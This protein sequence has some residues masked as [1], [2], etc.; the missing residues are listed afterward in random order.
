MGIN[1]LMDQALTA[2]EWRRQLIAI[3][4]QYLSSTIVEVIMERNFDS[5][6][7]SAD[8]PIEKVDTQ[9]ILAGISR[10]AALFL[11]PAEAKECMRQLK[12]DAPQSEE[13]G[14][15]SESCVL[16]I[17]SNSDVISAR[18]DAAQYAMDH[19]PNNLLSIRTSTV[20]SELAR[21]MVLYA[22]GGT[23]TVEIVGDGVEITARDDGP[24]IPHLDAV[25]AGRHRS[26]KG[27]GMGLRGVKKMSKRFD[28]VTAEGQ[29]TLI[30]LRL[31][32]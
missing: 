20:V 9:K 11:K 18:R 27:M 12:S 1:S 2:G 13:A 30:K 24:G 28:I 31:E 29:G 7:I 17:R 25:M 21:N 14:P 3:M 6:G 23:V 26:R 19:L 5:V 4:S 16:E 8:T 10:R 32:N 22:D 15:S